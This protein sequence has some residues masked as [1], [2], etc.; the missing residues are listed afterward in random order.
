[1][2]VQ[3]GLGHRRPRLRGQIFSSLATLK[4]AFLRRC[5]SGASFG[6]KR[7][8]LIRVT[9]GVFCFGALVSPTV[10]ADPKNRHRDQKILEQN[11]EERYVTLT[12]SR[13]PQKVKVKSIGTDSA[14]N[15]RIYTQRELQSTGRQTVADA[16]RLDPSIQVTG[17]H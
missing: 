14:H 11:A 6:M 17:G 5:N 10:K 7:M 13:I 3:A 16:L 1:M 2:P 8:T 9:I 15:I 4:N 12:G